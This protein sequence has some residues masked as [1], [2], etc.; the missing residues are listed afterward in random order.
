MARHG[1]VP[2]F[3]DD[4]QHG[5]E[6]GRDQGFMFE[7][8]DR[9][10]EDPRGSR[11]RRNEDRHGPDHSAH[12]DAHY[13]SWRDRHMQELDR[14]YDEFRRERE[15]Q[16]HHEFSAWRRQRTGNRQPLQPGRTQTAP[17]TDPSGAMEIARESGAEPINEPDAMGAATSGT[18]LSGTGGS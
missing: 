16:F 6:R 17:T 13:L 10:R 1:Y 5:D 9:E 14:D 15:Q 8:D 11:F 12:P 18:N 2:E 7:G 3:D 4:Y